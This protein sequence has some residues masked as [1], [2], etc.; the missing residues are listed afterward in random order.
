MPGK[1]LRP[2]D[3]SRSFFVA[4]GVEPAVPSTTS[5]CAA[6]KGV[7][8]VHA[9]SPNQAD[10]LDPLVVGKWLIYVSC[11][12]VGYCWPRVR[13]ATED[14]T[15]G[16]SAKVSTDWGKAHD[17]VGMIGAGRAGW[18]DHVICVYTVD[19]RN[20]EDVARVGS[21][22]AEIDAVRTQ[23]IHYKPDAF[24]YAGRYAGNAP[25]EVAVYSM[26]KPYHA[27]VEHPDELAALRPDCASPPSGAGR[28]SRLTRR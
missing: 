20:R 17:L 24:T 21:R 19:W 14:G 10:D 4:A 2:G 22:L 15:L 26:K 18:R 13:E 27:L 1:R 25:G 3:E 9:A 6:P 5:P 28:P 11:A 23:T 8:W 7:H 12:H 16:I